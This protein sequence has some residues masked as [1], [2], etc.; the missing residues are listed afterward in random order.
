MS[1]QEILL[2]HRTIWVATALGPWLVDCLASEIPELVNL[3]NS[4]QRGR[5]ALQ[6]PSSCP[7]ATGRLKARLRN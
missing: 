2:R 5:S 1:D 7:T 4:L 3:A 6:K